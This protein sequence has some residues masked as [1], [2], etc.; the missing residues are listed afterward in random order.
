MPAGEERS[1][2]EAALGAIDE[3]N[4]HDPNR[5]VRDGVEHPKELLHGRL[6]SEW[7]QRL[8][9][10]AGEEQLLAAR[11][12]HFRRWTSPRDAHP[13]G[14]AGYLRWRAEAARRQAEEVGELLRLHGYDE[15]TVERVGA[16]IRKEGRTRDPAVQ[17][18]EDALCL[19][20]LETQLAEVAERLGADHTRQVLVRTLGKMSERAIEQ[21]LALELPQDA[22]LLLQEALAAR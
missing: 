7:V 3:A 14:R 16:I 22:A 2:L 13:P 9:P 18:H 19:V 5:V 6:V 11:A 4:S 21:A 8:D 1:R 20:F 15:A 10:A 12:H 17:T